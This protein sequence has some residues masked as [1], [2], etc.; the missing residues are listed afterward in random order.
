MHTTEKPFTYCRE[1]ALSCAATCD[2]PMFYHL[3]QEYPINQKIVPAYHLQHAI[4]THVK[5]SD[6]TLLFSEFSSYTARERLERCSTSAGPPSK[7][8]HCI[9]P[10]GRTHRSHA[11]KICTLTSAIASLFQVI[12]STRQCCVCRRRTQNYNT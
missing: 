5:S 6:I 8:P 4:P 2:C 1:R 11:R 3:S 7:A 9:S 12:A 10:E